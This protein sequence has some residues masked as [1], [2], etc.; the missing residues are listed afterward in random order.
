MLFILINNI[1]IITKHNIWL[2]KSIEL[3]V[4]D[5]VEFVNI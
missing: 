5:Y 2:S 3:N 4:D 1:Q